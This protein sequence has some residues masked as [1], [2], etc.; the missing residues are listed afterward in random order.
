M[1]KHVILILVASL[2]TIGTSMAQ[3]RFKGNIEFGIGPTAGVLKVNGENRSALSGAVGDNCYL[4]Y[5]HYLRGPWGVYA[6]IS[7]I[8]A[9]ASEYSYFG[10]LN[11]ADGIKYRYRSNSGNFDQSYSSLFIVGAAY[12]MDYDRFDI[13]FRGGIGCGQRNVDFDYVR[14]VR[15]E[16]KGPEYF[17]LATQGEPDVDYLMDNYNSYVYYYSSAFV[18]EASAQFALKLGR[19]IRLFAQAGFDCSPSRS[20]VDV[21]YKGTKSQYDPINWVEAV[22]YADRKN[23]WAIDSDSIKTSTE[24]MGMGA[25]FNLS[26]GIGYSLW[27]K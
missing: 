17:Y 1:K 20:K 4:R 13:V 7:D 27:K 18:A 15:D 10:A 2:A 24:K 25:H 5:T 21:T 11:K 14:Q 9:Y 26:F 8:E 22:S 3:D 19:R 6:S 12:K 23:Y 16:S